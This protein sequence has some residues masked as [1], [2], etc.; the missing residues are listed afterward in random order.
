MTDQGEPSPGPSFGSKFQRL[1][2]FTSDL[3]DKIAAATE[4]A[5]A[6]VA[7][8]AERAFQ[9]A[10]TGL[11]QA[12]TAAIDFKD[13]L[14]DRL[15][16]KHKHG[17][18]VSALDDVA[19]MLYC[20]ILVR[21]ALADGRLDPREIANLYLFATTIDLDAA[22]RS[23]LR[24]DITESAGSAT[25][26]D[27]VGD[28]AMLLAA[29]LRDVLDPDE[30]KAVFAALIRDLVRMSRADLDSSE[31]ER[32]RIVAIAKIVFPFDAD[33]V[34]AATEELIVTEEKLAAGEIS[35]AQW[36]KTTKDVIA[37][38]AAFGAPVGAVSLL[39]SVSGLSAA[40]ITSG[41][42]TLGFGGLLGLSSMVTGIGVAVLLGVG[43]FVGVRYVLGFNERERENRREHLIQQVVLKHQEAMADLAEDI[44]GLAQKVQEAVASTSNNE[45][46]LRLLRQELACFQEAL[47]TLTAN[48]DA[49]VAEEPV[50]VP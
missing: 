36:E 12:A 49:F 25:S 18:D 11:G 43:V 45:E 27:D 17:V 14:V 21:L 6:Q 39:G 30:G 33:S 5:R 10:R 44:S 24:T 26:G 2:T 37:K 8:T 40:G 48:R 28:A 3:G 22:A 16:G 35:T 46:R 20:K 38:A 7:E 19:K 15:P 31:V 34:V 23:D 13:D 42:A 32:L 41:L 47:A 1:R 4:P 50:H 9:G 29:Q